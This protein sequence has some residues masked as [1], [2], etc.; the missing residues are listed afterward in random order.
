MRR[1]FPKR[2]I[3]SFIHHWDGS[4]QSQSSG[5]CTSSFPPG[6]PQ[7]GHGERGPGLPEFKTQP[8]YRKAVD[9]REGYLIGN[10]TARC[11]GGRLHD[12][13][14]HLPERSPG[15]LEFR[16]RKCIKAFELTAQKVTGIINVRRS[17]NGSH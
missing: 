1:Y 10:S 16:G 5:R 12:M 3:F 17:R 7:S 15:E 4:L 11:Y 6:R 13:P 14:A 2:P 9:P 8:C